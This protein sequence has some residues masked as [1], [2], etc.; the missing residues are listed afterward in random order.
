MTKTSLPLPSAQATEMRTLRRIVLLAFLAA[1]ALVLQVSLSMLPN[2]ELVSLWFLMLSL[3]LSFRESFLV[4]ILFTLLQALV[5]GVGDWVLGYL[6]VW[7]AWMILVKLLAPMIRASAFGWALLGGAF[8]MIFGLLFALQHA[9]LYG[10]TMGYLY[11]LRGISFDI[12][13]AFSNYSLI[14]ILYTP[15]S[16]VMQQLF[17]KWDNYASNNQSR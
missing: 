17:R 12:V 2:V 13:H 7:S 6:W 10:A 14:L 4:V 16:R 11:W 1:G 3:H 15:L 8:G 9:L 5:W